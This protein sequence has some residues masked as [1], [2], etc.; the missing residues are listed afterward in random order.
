MFGATLGDNATLIGAS[1]DVVAAGICAGHGK[2]V[3]FGRYLCYGLPIAGLQLAVSAL[4]FL[5]N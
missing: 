4:F 5:M 2:P 3:T 1:A